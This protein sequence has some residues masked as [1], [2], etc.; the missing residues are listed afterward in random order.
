[1]IGAADGGP[2][3]INNYN[4]QN[5]TK[6]ETNALFENGNLNDGVGGHF[7]FAEED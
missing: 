6:E 3:L 1:M 2:N 4:N 5:A 7:E